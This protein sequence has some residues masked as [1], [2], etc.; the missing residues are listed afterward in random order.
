MDKYMGIVNALITF[1]TTL[2]NNVLKGKL[3][4]YSEA[5]NGI[6]TEAGKLA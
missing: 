4:P 2:L 6:V 1:L 3:A 5:I